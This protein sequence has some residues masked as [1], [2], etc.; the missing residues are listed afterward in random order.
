LYRVKRPT[1]VGT[2]ARAMNSFE[3][4]DLRL[5]QP[6]CNYLARSARNT[7]KGAQHVIKNAIVV[8][9]L[10]EALNGTVA[11]VAFTRWLSQGIASIPCYDSIS[12]VV[13]LWHMLQISGDSSNKLALVFGGEDCGIE[14]SEILRCGRVCSIPMGRLQESLSLSHAVSLALAPLFEAA[15]RKATSVDLSSK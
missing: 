1:T 5:V 8:D 2:V 15:S 13:S 7:S 3:A 11:A 9:S 10:D 6:R 12:S 14:K 4:S